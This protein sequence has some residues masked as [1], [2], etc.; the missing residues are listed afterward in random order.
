M[1]DSKQIE[2]EDRIQEQS[3]QSDSS[4]K[5]Q[6]LYNDDQMLPRE[7]SQGPWSRPV[8]DTCQPNLAV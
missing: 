6:D 3:I 2:K 1:C 8:H 4:K 5:L 7:V